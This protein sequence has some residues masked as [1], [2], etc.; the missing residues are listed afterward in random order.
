M[1][2]VS[3]PPVLSYEAS[4]EY[5]SLIKRLH[6]SSELT[7][8]LGFFATNMRRMQVFPPHPLLSYVT[9]P[10]TLLDQSSGIIPDD[11]AVE[12]KVRTQ[13]LC[14]HPTR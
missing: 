7:L 2:P 12:E 4:Q 1:A 11:S 6:G 13:F 9:P 8:F 14:F 10:H 3:G 5:L